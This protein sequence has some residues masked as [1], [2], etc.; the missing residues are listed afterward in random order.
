MLSNEGNLK[1][2][3]RCLKLESTAVN[4]KMRKISDY[5]LN[6]GNVKSQ[7]N[8]FKIDIQTNISN[9]YPLKT[10]AGEV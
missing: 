8:S 5:K 6:K 2:Q 4:Y 1:L 7:T 9:T 3:I 10:I